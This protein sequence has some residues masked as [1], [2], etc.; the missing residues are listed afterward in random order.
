M[1]LNRKATLALTTL[2]FLMSGNLSVSSPAWAQDAPQIASSTKDKG[3][4]L[5][6]EVTDIRHKEGKLL[7][8]VFDKAAGFPKEID[9]A[10]ALIKILPSQPKTT[11]TGLPAGQYAVVVLHDRNNSGKMDKN[12]MGMPSE[13]VGLSNYQSIGL[14]NL[15][16][17]R[18]AAFELNRSG[19]L[20]V[21]LIEI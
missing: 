4:E 5:T 2:V 8:A 9:K 18:K 1:K 17:Y 13:P 3:F 11:F 20:K 7:I 21:K 10:I 14:T 15:P 16:D 6:V 12:F 19:L